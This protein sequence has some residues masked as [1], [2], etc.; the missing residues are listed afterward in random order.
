MPTVV[1]I[2]R[3]AFMETEGLIV[4]ERLVAGTA[5][6]AHDEREKKPKPRHHFLARSL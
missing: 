3:I 4:K 5:V 1:M 2:R 6:R